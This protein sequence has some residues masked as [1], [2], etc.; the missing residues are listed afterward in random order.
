[1]SNKKRIYKKYK[2][3]QS[4]KSDAKMWEC[5]ILAMKAVNNAIDFQREKLRATQ[6]SKNNFPSGIIISN[7]QEKILSSDWR[8]NSI[9][10][11]FDNHMMVKEKNIA[12]AWKE[13]LN[14]SNQKIQNEFP[15]K[16]EGMMAL[17]KTA[18]GGNKSVFAGSRDYVA[19]QKIK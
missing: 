17:M 12:D 13:Y 14:K 4:Q 3:M 16:L 2:A 5:I 10:H 8:N 18:D 19:K 1:M 9:I 11:P 7:E 6:L 15:K